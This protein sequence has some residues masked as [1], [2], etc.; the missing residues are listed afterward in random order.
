MRK[1]GNEGNQMYVSKKRLLRIF[2][3]LEIIMFCYVYFFGAQGWQ[4]IQKLKVENKDKKQEIVLMQKKLHKLELKIARWESH[5]FYKEK[6][7]RERLQMARK[8]E[9]IYYVD[10]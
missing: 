9:Q 3:G 10:A 7:A 2:F 6:L 1:L 4:Y 5:P 8:D